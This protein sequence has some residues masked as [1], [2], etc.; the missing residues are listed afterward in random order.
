MRFG[1]WAAVGGALFVFTSSCDHSFDTERQVTSR[2]S[3]GEEVYRVF[4]QR[5]AASELPDDVSGVQSRALCAGEA[6]P[7]TA[8]TPRLR[9]L[10]ENRARAVAALDQVMP[11][12]LEDDLDRFMLELVPFYDPPEELLPSQTRALGNLLADLAADEEAVAALERLSTRVGYR[13]LRLALGVARPLMAY[14]GLSEFT[15]VA[16]DTIDEG[17]SAGEEWDEL[18][19]GIALE[20]ATA[21][22]S[23]EEDGPSTLELTRE[24]MFRT[25]PEF[26]SGPRRLMAVR[27]RRGL[28]IPFSADGTLPAPFVDRNDDGLA[29][30]DVLGRFIDGS[31]NLLDLPAPFAYV[32]ES[33]ALRDPAGRAVRADMTPLYEYRDINQSLLAGLAREAVGWLDPAQPTLMDMAFG[34]PVVLGPEATRT[35]DLGGV[36]VEY[37]G[38]DTSEG[39]L[40]D[41]VYGA[42]E[43]LHRDETDD[44]LALTELL[45][46][47]HEAEVAA[48]IEAGLRGDAVADVTEAALAPDSE[49]WDDLIQVA[50]W[51]AQEPGLLEALLRSFADPRSKRLGTIY[52]EMMRH[53]D[54]VGFDPSDLN[55]PMRDQVWTEEV[56]RSRPEA[57]GNESLF[58]QSIAIIHDLDGVRVCNKEGAV[59]RIDLGV[60][61]ARWPLFGGARECE[62]IEIED[63]AQAYAL[64]IVGRY[65]LDIKDDTLA[66]LLDIG[67]GLGLDPDA[68]LERSSGIDG[69]TTHP[70]PEAMNRL[71]FAMEGNEFLEGIFDPLPTRDSVPVVERHD[72]IV[73]AWER[74]F[75]FCGDELVGPSAPCSSPEEVTFY[76]AMS[77]LIEAFDSNDRRTDG[78]FLFSK[79][80]SAL[81]LHWPSAG[82]EQTQASDPTAPFF[83]H[84]DDARSYEPI[85][86]AL[87]GDCAWVGAGASRRCDPEGAGQ[88][89]S[90][91]HALSAALD[92]VEVRP[93]VDGIDVLADATEALVDPARNP[94]LVDRRGRSTTTTN[95]GRSIP[96]TPLHLLV[97]PLS[98]FDRAFAAEPERLARWRG[99]RGVLV[100]QL[101]A[102]RDAAG[103]KELAN[104]RTYGVLRELLPFLRARIDDHRRRGDLREWAT[105]LASRLEDTM[106]SAVGAAAMRFAEAVN[107]DEAAEEQVSALAQY[108]MDEA[109]AN[110]AFDTT[111]LATA[112]LLQVLDDETNLDPLLRALS[113]GIVPGV[114]A[115]VAEGGTI[116]AGSLDVR[117]SAVDETL[118]LLKRVTDIDDERT[119]QALLSN[120]VALPEGGAQATPLETLLDVVAEVHRVEP[121]QGGPMRAD[122]HR[123][124][125][126]TATEFL[127][128][129]DHGLERIYSVVQSRQLED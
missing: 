79:L 23:P 26:G 83:A 5:L 80:I 57:A 108:L 22:P 94:G 8:P 73:F 55:R 62:L 121:N 116:R 63:V 89:I 61:N 91:L 14:D 42:G 105:S 112:D 93:G 33:D 21:A 82:A 4:C 37:R 52:A 50:Q 76:E 100:D 92:A 53:R 97:D 65:T 69:L 107:A 38:F 40:F 95:G 106:G 90:R 74:S 56:D 115:R 15:R 96:L 104:R 85:I 67:R 84:H 51:I 43:L 86:A 19:Q 45:L 72:P 125:L 27:D 24:L 7:E 119:L 32:G 68:I 118:I 78:R 28:A 117:G 127:L 25:R 18:L 41:L 71:V 1:V 59:L 66:W 30:V 48:M 102:V 87:F 35:E 109:S 77:P 20:L 120:L 54:A 88:L 44:V 98:E 70:T 122:D 16:L 126:N 3:L 17:G 103:G 29:D 124:V 114:R 58:Q 6:A 46:A 60:I 64:A 128:D 123:R 34:L 101:L 113:E 129:E 10:A 9:A 110:D 11:E 81:H 111:V 12:P 2:G 13:P 39:P 99:G 47:D 31:G 75:R 36:T 49:L